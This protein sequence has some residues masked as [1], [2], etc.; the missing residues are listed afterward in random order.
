MREVLRKQT[1]NRWIT[2]E[3]QEIYGCH[4]FSLVLSDMKCLPMMKFTI[5]QNSMKLHFK[6]HPFYGM[7]SELCTRNST[8]LGICYF[9]LG[10]HG[11]FTSLCGLFRY[12]MYK[13][14]EESKLHSEVW[15]FLY[16]IQIF[17]LLKYRRYVIYFKM[18]N[19]FVILLG[20]SCE[21]LRLRQ[22]YCFGF[23]AAFFHVWSHVIVHD[24]HC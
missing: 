21:L 11:I 6:F 14:H 22:Y 20:G 1:V 7:S 23:I 3:F 19:G 10:Y 9:S 12:A 8:F 5:C 15:I 13:L 4:F 16:K 2:L 24:L 18:L 17:L